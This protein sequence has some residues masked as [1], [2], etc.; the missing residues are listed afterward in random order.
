[1]KILKDEFPAYVSVMPT[2][3][4]DSYSNLMSF[5]VTEG[6]YGHD[7]TRVVVTDTRVIVAVDSNDGPMIIFSED[8][9]D[10]HKSN[11]KT[12]DSYVVTKTGKILAFR[13]NESCGCGSRLRGWNPYTHVYSSKDPTE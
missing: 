2:G 4:L 9:E 12:Y 7:K 10:F 6:A 11:V 1:M 5:P 8:Y 13:R 3:M